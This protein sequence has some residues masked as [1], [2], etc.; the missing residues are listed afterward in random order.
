MGLIPNDVQR[1][2]FPEKTLRD[3][4][5]RLIY[6]SPNQKSVA[7]DLFGAEHLNQAYSRLSKTLQP[8]PPT[9]FDIDWFIPTLRTLGEERADE[10]MRFLGEQ[11]G[12]KVTKVRAPSIDDRLDALE[13]DFADAANRMRTAAEQIAQLRKDAKR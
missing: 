12:Y 10:A 7:V 9:F 5:R 1:S 2:L 4:L 6:G 8:D 11:L 13:S 3:L